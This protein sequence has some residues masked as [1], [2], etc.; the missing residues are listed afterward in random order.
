[1]S[2]KDLGEINESYL[3][4]SLFERLGIRADIK[5]RMDL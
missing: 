5:Y 4:T 2:W 1:M 3:L